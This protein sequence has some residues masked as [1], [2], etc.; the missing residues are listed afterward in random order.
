MCANDKFFAVFAMAQILPLTI[1]THLVK[2]HREWCVYIKHLYLVLCQKS[3]SKAFFGNKPKEKSRILKEKTD[4]YF[5]FAIKFGF[6]KS[7]CN[8]SIPRPKPNL[9]PLP[10]YRTPKTARRF[11]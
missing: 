8:F 1:I 5:R 7:V 3:Q 4:L 11:R 6:F 10:A 9:R 2:S